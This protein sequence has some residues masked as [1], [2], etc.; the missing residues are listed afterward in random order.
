MEISLARLEVAQA[1]RILYAQGVLDAFGHVS[2]RCT[3]ES[4]AFLMS[5]SMAPGLVEV[6]DV[7]VHNAEGE[8]ADGGANPFLER[9]IHAGIYRARS[10][11]QAIVHSHCPSVLPFAMVPEVRLRSICHTCGFLN[12]LGIPFEISQ[13]SGDSS[14]LLISNGGLGDALAR[15]LGADAVVL[16]RGHGFTTVGASLQ[17]AVFRAIYTG[18]AAQVQ[19]AAMQIGQPR[20]LSAGEAEACDR[21]TAGQMSRAW[22][23]WLT[24]LNYSPTAAEKG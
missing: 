17:E 12:T 19:M 11:V 23:L 18:L 1:S 21:T 3:A 7:L 15:H 13:F 10:D 20:Y 4:G 2:R 16:M 6:A 8:I 24:Q 5:R 22:E 14:N 9:F